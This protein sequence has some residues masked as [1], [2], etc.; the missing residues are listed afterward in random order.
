MATTLEKYDLDH[1]AWLTGLA[2]VVGYGVIVFLLFVALF[3][4]P[5]LVFAL[6]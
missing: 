2:T 5:F 3:I 6:L 4:V 1:P